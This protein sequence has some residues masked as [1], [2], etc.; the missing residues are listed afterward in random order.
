L[1]DAQAA[2]DN[3]HL[4]ELFGKVINVA[5]AKPQTTVSHKAGWYQAREEFSNV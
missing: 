4:S 2:L 5:V 3:M 1:E